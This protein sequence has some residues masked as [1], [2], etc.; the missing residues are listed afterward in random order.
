MKKFSS[1]A[2]A[3]SY[4]NGTI[5]MTAIILGDDNK[6]WVVSLAKMEQLLKS[7]YEVI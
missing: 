7:G 2:L 1:E 6:F 3:R 4:S 5:K